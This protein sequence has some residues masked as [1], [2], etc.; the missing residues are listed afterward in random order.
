MNLKVIGSSSKGNC[1]IL[2]G[3]RDQ[4]LIECGVKI[5]QIVEAFDYSLQALKGCVL[6]HGHKDHSLSMGQLL[7][8]SVPVYTSAGTAGDLKHHNLNI[9]QAKRPFD[10]GEFRVMPFDTIHDAEEPLGFMIEQ[11]SSGERLLFATDTYYI[12]YKF[13]KLNYLVIE[14]NHS[15]SML[16][17][18]VENGK[19]H[20]SLRQRIQQ[21]HMS[22]ETLQEFLMANDIQYVKKIVLIH[23]SDSNSDAKEFKKVIEDQ[24]GIETIV[25][26]PVQNI[27]LERFPF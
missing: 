13:K 24:T 18:N 2:S 7:I 12:K 21:S 11:K 6:T 27:K 3:E 19:L 20:P 9:I 25:A 5:N 23:L 14:A 8:R 10:I 16:D 1:Y 15:T 26:E 4:I 22:L 17:M